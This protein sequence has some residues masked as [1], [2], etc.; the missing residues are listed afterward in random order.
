MRVAMREF[1]AARGVLEVETPLVVGAPVTDV[2]LQ[3]ATV[4]LG[5]G[6]RRWLATSPEYAMKRLLA[7]GSGDVWQECRVVRAGA[8]RGRHHNPEFTLV[9]WYRLGFD[10]VA[11]AGEAAALVDALLVAAGASPRGIEFLTYRDAL[12]RH[13]G[14]DPLEDEAAR[15]REA[16][17]GAGLPAAALAA[18]SRDDL[19]DLLVA[20]RVG[21]AL[22][23]DRLCALTHYPASQAALARLDPQ[24]R[25]VAL[26]FELY[27][28]G[29]ELAN[30]FEELGDAREQAARFD[31]DNARR[32]ALGRETLPVD[33]RL[34]AAL[35][36]GL[37][38]CAGVAVGFDRV[39]MLAGGARAIDE[40]LAFP[41]EHA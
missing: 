29:L 4:D 32:H 37:P 36:A 20:T 3:S 30:G 16:V 31:A 6:V 23:A 22:G 5:D 33:A 15:L 17:A 39:A 28:G 40:V 38:A 19:L 41:V 35:T 34:L 9:E 2:H 13:A 7:A 14:V 10:M 18:A 12:L 26:R 11:M 1:F 8:E 24:D 21:P 25:R 27:G